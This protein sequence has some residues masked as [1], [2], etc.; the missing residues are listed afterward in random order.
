MLIST[1]A[2]LYKLINCYILRHSPGSCCYNLVI[3]KLQIEGF[4]E[5][6]IRGS[7]WNVQIL[8]IFASVALFVVINVCNDW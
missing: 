7:L 8:K 6:M 3:E 5:I 4:E 2:M 1:T